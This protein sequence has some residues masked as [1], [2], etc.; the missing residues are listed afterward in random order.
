MDSR[1]L[2]ILLVGAMGIEPLTSSVS[3]WFFEL[4]RIYQSL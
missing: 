3:R 2:L 4:S 1:N